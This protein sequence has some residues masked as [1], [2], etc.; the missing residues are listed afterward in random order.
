MPPIWEVNFLFIVSKMGGLDIQISNE[1]EILVRAYNIMKGSNFYNIDNRF[2][3]GEDRFSAIARLSGREIGF[4][5]GEINGCEAPMD[6]DIEDPF[7]YSGYIFVLRD[8]RGRG[9]GEDIKR[10]QIQFAKSIGCKS[11]YCEVDMGREAS[12]G[13]QEKL[14]ARIRS[15]GGNYFECC[16]D[17]ENLK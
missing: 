6:F 17:L 16:F 2:F 11:L 3:D 8:F 12:L 1:K 7:F 14:G 15:G 9:F 10:N 4:W 13:I 5:D